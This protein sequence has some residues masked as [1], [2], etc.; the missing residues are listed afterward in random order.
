MRKQEIDHI[1]SNML[2]AHNNVSDLNITVGRQFQVE[3][4]GLLV[5]AG[6]EGAGEVL[7]G[8]SPFAAAR[9]AS[10]RQS[11]VRSSRGMSRSVFFLSS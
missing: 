4:A 8:Y 11:P 5:P 9:L 6:L 3:S 1:L 7:G 2:D 10:R